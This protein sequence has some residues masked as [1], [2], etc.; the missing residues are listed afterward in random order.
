MKLSDF[1][2]EE[3]LD[4]LADL[5][6]PVAIIAGD[7]E[8]KAIYNSGRPK[9]YLVKYI[10][11]NHKKEIIE[12]LAILDKEDPAT[13][14]EKLTLITLPTKVIELFNDKDLQ[15]LFQSQSQMNEGTS[16]GS[17]TEITEAEEN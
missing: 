10:I 8:V 5:L 12:I 15:E 14:A 1:K 2:G 13:Y 6:D 11:K 9:L 17:A 16:S 4:I 7:K 3:A